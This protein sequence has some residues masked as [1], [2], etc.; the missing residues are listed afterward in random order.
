MKAPES[1]YFVCLAW[2]VAASLISGTGRVSE[3]VALVLGFALAVV[4]VY[5][6]RQLIANEKGWL[7]RLLDM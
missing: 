5:G 2:A 4:I 1:A 6:G 3:V 7:N